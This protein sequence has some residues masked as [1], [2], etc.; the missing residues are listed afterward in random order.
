MLPL[1]PIEE[2]LA[3]LQ[4]EAHAKGLYL[5][6]H[7]KSQLPEV[8]AGDE[9]RVRQ[10]MTA[11]V[12]N[13]IR[14]TDK[15]GVDVALSYDTSSNALSI[16]VNDSGCGVSPEELPRIFQRSPPGGDLHGRIAPGFGIGLSV[17]Q[18]LVDLMG[19]RIDIESVLNKGTKVTL[20]FPAEVMSSP[21]TPNKAA[22]AS[23]EGKAAP[24]RILVA[25][26]NDANQKIL[27]GLLTAAGYLVTIVADGQAAV[28]AVAGQSFDVVLM[29][30]MMPVMDGGTATRII[31]EREKSAGALPIVALTAHARFGDRESFLAS[32]FTDYLPK[33]LDIEALFSVLQRH[34]VR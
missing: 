30:I 5:N 24:L 16:C 27:R 4:S 31:R 33:P 28:D 10:I 19:G 2:A 12:G 32:G 7:Q 17:V 20:H 1:R 23:P 22:T 8:V 15:G 26:D 29:D 21:A 18:Q 11:L 9:R 34:T 3:S 13:A 25:E 6:L 14:F